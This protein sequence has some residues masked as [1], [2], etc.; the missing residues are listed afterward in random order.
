MGLIKEHAYSILRIYSEG[1][2]KIINLRNPWG[3]FEWTGDWSD[4]SNKWTEDMIK[5]VKP[6]LEEDDG[7]FWISYEHF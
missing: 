1:E 5:K 4:E 3:V 6:S 7:S 2:I